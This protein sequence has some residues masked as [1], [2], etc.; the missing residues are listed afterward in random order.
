MKQRTISTKL[1]TGVGALLLAGVGVIAFGAWSLSQMDAQLHE[2][3]F[4]TAPK[5]DLTN[6]FRARTW[7]MVAGQRGAYILAATGDA[8]GVAGQT[9]AWKKASER[10]HEQLR[11]LAPLLRTGD[12]KR[13]LAQMEEGL[14]GYERTAQ[15]GFRLIER[16]ALTEAAA[17]MPASVAAA[18]KL[19]E[20]GRAMTN[21]QR[22]RL[23]EAEAAAERIVSFNTVGLVFAGALFLLCSAA[24]AHVIRGVS[25]ELRLAVRQLADGAN[26][27][28]AAAGQV[29]ATS[30]S[31]AQ[32][33][34]EQAASIEEI[35]ASGAQISAMART[36]S[37]HSGSAAQ[38]VSEAE[39]RF[40]QT[41]QS[42]DEM[43]LAMAE[44]NGQSE[45]ISKII[46]VIDE[47][48]FQT[49]ILALNAAV[50][51]A[52]AGEAGMGF[53]VV[54]DEV[55]AL[56]Q[57]CSQAAKDTA[58]LIEESIVKS[59]GGKSKVDL[60]ASS[61]KVIFEEVRRVKGL[62]DEVSSGSGQQ[63]S[64]VEQVTLAIGQME[65][66]T[67]KTAAD[68]EESAAAAEELNA[69][70]ESVREVARSLS[71]MVNGELAVTG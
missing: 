22:E 60:V 9:A 58:S 11:E 49:N 54:A 38:L 41:A 15:E 25:R 69:Q 4:R 17:Q 44:I 56:A 27:V 65:Q 39:V 64:G 45:K 67:Q 8:G 57:R 10:A 18:V 31:L 37:E 68:A 32:G 42:L 30:Q 35:S 24:A 6:A 62:V 40:E 19:D 28:S 13:L 36:N 46:K 29:S 20:D 34:S 26:Q 66:V 53:A 33:A 43:V 3:I 52:R 12:A 70:S 61:I 48:A 47:I 5:I 55:R 51:A 21:L 1:F 50:E 14:A 63:S 7:E 16:N 2:S 23:A 59:S 71:L